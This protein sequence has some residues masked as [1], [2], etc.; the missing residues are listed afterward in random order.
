M[1]NVSVG[2]GVTAIRTGAANEKGV[3]VGI[4][5]Q[6]RLGVGVAVGTGTLTVRVARGSGVGV[7]AGNVSCERVGRV[8]E[9][10]RGLNVGVSGGNVKDGKDS[11]GADARPPDTESTPSKA[12]PTTNTDK[13]MIHLLRFIS[14]PSYKRRTTSI[15]VNGYR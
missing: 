7:V 10:S 12:P 2:V 3:D 9:E 4:G 11:A 8:V 14:L 6:V 5:V 13:T 1:G 15:R